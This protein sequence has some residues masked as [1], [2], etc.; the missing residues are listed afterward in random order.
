MLRTVSQAGLGEAVLVRGPEGIGARHLVRW[1]AER[2][3]ELGAARGIMVSPDTGVP[4]ALVSPD[5]DRV[6]AELVRLAGGRPLV[7]GL[8]RAD[9]IAGAA[10]IV[11][12]TRGLPA[13]VLCLATDSARGGWS[14]RAGERVGS[15][16]ADGVLRSPG[17]DPGELPVLELSP[18]DPADLRELVTSLLPLSAELAEP[19]LHKASGAPGAAMKMVRRL[20]EDR[21]LVPTRAGWRLRESADLDAVLGSP[22]WSTSA[23]RALAAVE[24][25]VL[26]R[27]ARRGGAASF[28]VWEELCLEVG[29]SDAGTCLARLSRA[30]WL[31]PDHAAVR[32]GE[33]VADAVIAETS[34]A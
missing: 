23:V 5:E 10:R 34:A 12:A 26:A 6:E 30:G 33:G 24:R 19:I 17:S 29:I 21:Q 25:E 32:L 27:L 8:L 9:Q 2:G 28:D 18:L 15:P 1:V 31:E 16:G 3:H 13:P 4:E 20:A 22:T 14:T 11:R 7:V